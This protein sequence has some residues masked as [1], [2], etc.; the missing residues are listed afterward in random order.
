LVTKL[1]IDIT[2]FE[3]E[4]L[5]SDIESK[6]FYHVLHTSEDIWCICSIADDPDTGEETVLLFHDYP[7]FDEVEVYDKYDDKSYTIPKRVGTLQDGAEFWYNVGQRGGKLS[8]HNCCTFDQPVMDKIWPDLKI[9]DETYWDTFVQ[10]KLQWFDRHQHKG[11]GIK[12]AHGLANYAAMNGIHKPQVDDWTTMDAFKLHRVVED[13]KT[14]R[15]AHE[16]LSKEFNICRGKLGV[17]FT[18]ALKTEHAYARSCWRQEL[19]GVLVD[20]EHVLRCIKELDIHIEALAMRLEPQLPMTLKI[21]GARVGRK[22]LAALLGFK[23]VVEDQYDDFGKM[24]KAYYKPTANPFKIDKTNNYE[25]FHLSHGFSPSFVK[26][27][28][29]TDWISENYPDTKTKDWDITKTEVQA[30]L[31]NHHAC[32]WFG[33]SETDT[34]VV[35]GPY[36]R[37]SYEQ[38]TMSQHEIVKGFLIQLGWKHAEE[39]NVKKDSDKVVM[40]AEKDTWVFY[41]KRAHPSNQLKVLCKKGQPLFTSP[42]LTE[43]DYVQLPEGIGT[44][45]ATYNTYMHR[46]RYLSNPKDPE[47]K[48]ILAAIREDGRLGAGVNNFGTRTSRASHRGIVNLPAKKSLYGKEMRQTIIAPEGKELVGVDQKSSQLSIAA[49]VANN[50][51]YYDAVANGLE[52]KMEEDGSETYV[53]SSAHCVNA[54]YFNLVTEE[55][56]HQAVETQDPELLESIALRRGTSKGL[57]FASLFGC[58]PP[59][60]AVMGKFSVPEAKTKLASFLDGMGLTKVQ[61]FLSG[62]KQKYKRTKGFYIPSAFGYWIYC[63]SD[64]KAVNMLIQSTEAAVQKRAVELAEAR[65][66]E[67]YDKEEVFKV[68]DMHDEVLFETPEGLGIEVGKVLCECY[69]QAGKDLLDWYLAHL[70]LYPGEGTP[71]IACDFA[72]G[73][74]VGKDYYECH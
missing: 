22:E 25:G 29:L 4:T 14:Q 62:C 19:R 73:Y 65:L 23:Q 26:K 43:E 36:T 38:S 12:S 20:K 59:K 61:E 67:L 24:V 21:K 13:V 30:K 31:L 1:G 8:I 41:P 42:K 2:R 56:W 49:F 45:I 33:L 71:T 17:D 32:K 40:R 18:E 44:E 60:L 55:E 6:G 15:Y 58:A 7:E 51:T 34:D 46:R 70:D 64:H 10:S 48:G 39:W 28:D 50:V 52:V 9:P 72:G 54:R 74:A 66:E 16:Y 68:L 35:V 37:I 69:T 63:N 53:G 5:F 47:E 27:K 11:A 3:T 57:S